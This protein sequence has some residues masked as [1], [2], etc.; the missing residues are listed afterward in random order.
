MVHP[1][2]PRNCDRLSRIAVGTAVPSTR[3]Y[4]EHD[5]PRQTSR[6][7]L[8]KERSRWDACL[9]QPAGAGGRRREELPT[10]VPIGSPATARSILPS[11][12]K[13][14]TRIG[15]LFSMHMPIAVMS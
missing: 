2:S 12:L 14:N 13:L 11:F 7:G 10:Q 8:M 9:T 4:H 1:L 6:V 15:R 5:R 3:L